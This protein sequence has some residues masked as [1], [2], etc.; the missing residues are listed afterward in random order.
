MRV[1]VGAFPPIMNW[2]GIYSFTSRLISRQRTD[3]LQDGELRYDELQDGKVKDS[4]VKD[5]KVKDRPRVTIRR[6]EICLWGMFLRLS[7]R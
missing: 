2:P 4:K 1:W 3:T 5:S 6:P 7:S